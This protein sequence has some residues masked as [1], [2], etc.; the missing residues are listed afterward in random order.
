MLAVALPQSCVDVSNSDR[1]GTAKTTSK[2]NGLR[3]DGI[4]AAHDIDVTNEEL[5]DSENQM[6][7]GLAFAA[8]DTQHSH[9]LDESG[10]PADGIAIPPSASFPDALLG[11]D[12]IPTS[13][14]Y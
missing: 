8:V 1:N 7:E 12:Q 9:G 4:V 14:R 10:I 3:P 5:E 6:Q 13:S 11:I 2:V